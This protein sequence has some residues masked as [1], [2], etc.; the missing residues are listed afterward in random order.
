MANIK[1][2]DI[3]ARVPFNWLSE[4]DSPSKDTFKED[5]AFI[6]TML[7]GPTLGLAYD[8]EPDGYI[9]HGDRGGMTAMYKLFI[10]GQEGLRFE[11]IELLVTTIERMGG[12][13]TKATAAD[14]EDGH[15][16]VQ[17]R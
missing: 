8:Y 17:Y 4:Y 1:Q 5:A 11:T 6:A 16:Y 2:V 7:A 9:P 14:I 12:T 13:V 3:E 15:D 10:W